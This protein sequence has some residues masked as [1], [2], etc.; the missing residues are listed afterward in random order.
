MTPNATPI[1]KLDVVRACDLLAEELAPIRMIVEPYIP[2]GLFLVA[3][4]P[5]A[6]KTLLMQDLALS[7]TR[8]EPA[9]GG[10][11]V[12]QGSAL[13]LA[14]EGGQ[15]S[16]RDRIVKMLEI[17]TD[18]E[19]YSAKDFEGFT[20][21]LDITQS[22]EPLGERLEVQL[23]WWLVEAED[24]RLIV[25]DTYSSVAPETRGANR[26]QEDYNGLA[27][28]ADL[29]TRWPNTLFVVV[30]HTRK[31]DGDDI[32]H[33]ISGSN[34]MAAA[35]DG[36]AVLTRSTAARQCLLSIRPRNAE[37][38]EL[39]VERGPNLRWTVLGDDERATLSEGR[40]RI[41]SWLDEN[42]NG[43]TPKVISEALDMESQNVRQYLT[44]MHEARQV[45]KPRRGLYQ[46][47][48]RDET[49]AA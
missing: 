46:P 44:Q 8:G 10:L 22:S 19:A 20:G 23:E 40:Q 11:H 43:G 15:R 29:A 35:T 32:M 25:I 17:D 48:V 33:K 21:P 6:G 12:D 28:L 16:F 31:M 39:V 3:G 14:N 27:G 36:M 18:D 4:D 47:V 26:H 42:P 34:G 9:W 2:A 5:K 1:P 49:E 37:E 45:E 13:Y 38:S 30:H 24:P 7:I 41:L